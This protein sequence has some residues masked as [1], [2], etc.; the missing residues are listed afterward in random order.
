MLSEWSL[1]K[2]LLECLGDVVHMLGEGHLRLCLTECHIL[3]SP[4][5]QSSNNRRARQVPRFSCV[6]SRYP[7]KA[8][9]ERIR[10]SLLWMLCN[11]A[12]DLTINIEK[13]KVY[14]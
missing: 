14:V 8:E 3:G 9:K 2:C 11:W 13:Q 4:Q 6:V 1:H 10:C 12:A 7:V 5:V